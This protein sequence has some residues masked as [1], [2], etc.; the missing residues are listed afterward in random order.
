L[1][2]ESA[3]GGRYRRWLTASVAIARASVVESSELNALGVRQYLFE[4][5]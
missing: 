4:R 1:G 5:V 2:E 3:Q